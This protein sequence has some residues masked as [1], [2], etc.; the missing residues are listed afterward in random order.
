MQSISLSNRY[1]QKEEKQIVV[2][3]IIVAIIAQIVV[4]IVLFK[5]ICSFM[6]KLFHQASYLYETEASLPEADYMEV[7]YDDYAVKPDGVSGDNI[8]VTGTV[9]QIEKELEKDSLF[10]SIYICEDFETLKI[11]KVGYHLKENEN[12]EVGDILTFY[13]QSHGLVKRQMLVTDEIVYLPV[14]RAAVVSDDDVISGKTWS[15]EGS[16]IFDLREDGTCTVVFGKGEEDEVTDNGTYKVYRGRS[17]VAYVATEL[18]DLGLTEDEIISAFDLHESLD[19]YYCLVLFRDKGVQEGERNTDEP[20]LFY[21]G[22]YLEE[23][24]ELSMLNSTTL[25]FVT[26]TEV[27]E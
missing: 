9:T 11:W 2:L 14:I 5:G 16:A 18:E 21:L 25:S 8:K 26:L 15:V 12:I 22:L 20:S 23:T 6:V 10:L 7:S 24:G 4:F 3:F 17:A 19:D 13:G 1:S 27:T